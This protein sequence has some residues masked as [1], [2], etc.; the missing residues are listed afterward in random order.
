[1][2]AKNPRFN[3]LMDAAKQRIKATGGI[4]HD[5]F[6]KLVEQSDTN[7]IKARSSRS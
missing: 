5:E 4:K 6:W 7:K 1:M 3:Q 2:L